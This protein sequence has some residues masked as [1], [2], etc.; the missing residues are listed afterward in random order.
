MNIIQVPIHNYLRFFLGICSFLIFSQSTVLHAQDLAIAPKPSWVKDH[1]I[2]FDSLS[3][4]KATRASWYRGEIVLYREIQINVDTEEYYFKTVY[5]VPDYNQEHVVNIQ[6]RHSAKDTDRKIVGVS[7]IKEGVEKEVTQR[8]NW[9]EQISNEYVYNKLWESEKGLSLS[10]DRVNPGDL[11]VL[12]YV[13]KSI[14]TDTDAADGI[15]VEA[16]DSLDVYVRII[17]S[18]ALRHKTFNGFPEFETHTHQ[19]HMEYVAEGNAI[20]PYKGRLPNDFYEKSFVC[21]S[22]FE[23]LKEIGPIARERFSIGQKSH[24]VLDELYTHLIGE[25]DNDSIKVQKIVNYVQDS[26]I[27][28]DYGLIRTYQ[29]WWCIKGRRGDCKAKSLIS[30]ELLKRANIQAQAVLVKSPTYMSQFD[31]IP[32]FFNFNHLIVEFIFQ[33]DTILMDPTIP[34]QTDKIGAYP[35]PEYKKGLVIYEDQV[36]LRE[37]PAMN[38]GKME[39]FEDIADTV[40][41]KII[42]R[43]LYAEKNNNS[44][45][46]GYASS[47]FGSGLYGLR[48]EDLSIHSMERYMHSDSELGEISSEHY[49]SISQDSLVFHQ[50]LYFPDSV[51]KP[52]VPR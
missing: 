15:F 37:M 1:K 47:L 35:L 11:Y 9:N 22:R 4:K 17:S 43:G 30:I 40:S 23:D 5:K 12:S 51:K 8:I 39:I 45:S 48:L 46:Y 2:P 41:R 7:L 3:K 18:Q 38:P 24:E 29:P 49:N 21:F 33:G 44:Q 50:S 28:Q 6:L 52:F 31:S 34:K 42:L 32:S 16:N 26:I 14:R 20:T 25:K 27:Y 19:D 13:D 10:V 36:G